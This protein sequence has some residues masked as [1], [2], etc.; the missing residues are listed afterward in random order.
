MASGRSIDVLD[1][2]AV[3]LADEPDL[4]GAAVGN[5][6][7]IAVLPPCRPVGRAIAPKLRRLALAA[8]AAVDAA[9]DAEIN[10]ALA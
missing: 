6:R 5:P 8:D 2:P 10:R 7:A 4:V 9:I 1:L 3:G